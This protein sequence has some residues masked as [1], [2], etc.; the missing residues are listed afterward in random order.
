MF[1]FSSLQLSRPMLLAS[2]VLGIAIPALATGAPRLLFVA[3]NDVDNINC[4]HSA[5][6]CRSIG[7]AIS[8]AA[9]GDQIKV[10]PGMY[11]DINQDGVL[12]G[13]GEEPRLAPQYWL[14]LVNKRL[15]SYS[16]T[17]SA[18]T[19]IVA[20]QHEYH[21]QLNVVHITANGVAFGRAGGGFT[22]LGG[23]VG[24]DSAVVQAGNVSVVGNV[25]ANGTGPASDCDDVG[26]RLEAQGGRIVASN[27][28]ASG[29][30]CAGFLATA[31]SDHSHVTLDGNTATGNF[32][33]FA[34]GTVDP[35]VTTNN[36]SIDNINGFYISGTSTYMRN[37]VINNSEGGFVVAGDGG[38]F[39]ENSV[40]GNPGGGFIVHVR[41]TSN[42]AIHR[43]NIFANGAGENSDNCGVRNG[44]LAIVDARENY[45]G[46]ASGPGSDPA[47]NADPGCDTGGGRTITSHFPAS[48]FPLD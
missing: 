44:S 19:I 41:Q 48:K 17:G 33:G 45:W 46:A 26:F 30:P 13:P 1:T 43:N 18:T 40:I 36:V 8:N 23:G 38:T 2:L 47:D 28:V 35:D 4:G 32:I 29:H 34:V 42:V 14:V 5:N 25:A 39:L 31:V 3:N 10:G 24:I 9:D 16:Q 11:G 21:V 6:R 22:I 20:P 37:I 7:Q 15:A 27:N 12:D